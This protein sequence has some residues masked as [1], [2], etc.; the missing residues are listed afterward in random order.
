MKTLMK[1]TMSM[2]KTMAT[3]QHRVLQ[4]VRSGFP[5]TLYSLFVTKVF[6]RLYGVAL[7]PP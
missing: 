1:V 6:V 7:P 3:A 2:K 4:I 5:F